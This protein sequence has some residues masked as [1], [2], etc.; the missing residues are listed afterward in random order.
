[1]DQMFAVNQVC[2]KYLANV[3]D[4]FWEFNGFGKGI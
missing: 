3:K 4:Y 1:M 2:N